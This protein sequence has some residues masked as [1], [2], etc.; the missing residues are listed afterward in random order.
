MT[1]S[2]TTSRNKRRVKRRIDFPSVEEW[3][4]RT[5]KH[6][7]TLHSVSLCQLFET[8]KKQNPKMYIYTP[9]II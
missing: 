7:R 2:K 6:R 5:L 9:R 1:R 4:R 3:K 8:A